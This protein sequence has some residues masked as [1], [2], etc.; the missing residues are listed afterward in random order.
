MTLRIRQGS[1]SFPPYLSRQLYDHPQLRPLLL[2]GEHIALFGR[3]KAALRRKRELVDVDELRR[4][5]DPPHE[6]IAAL[7]LAAL[8]GYQSEHDGL[9]LRHE[10]QRLETAGALGVV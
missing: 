6:F 10:P 8:A 2:L 5:V 7:E 4:L 3:G 1:N 9:A